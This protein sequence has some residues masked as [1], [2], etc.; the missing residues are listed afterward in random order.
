MAKSREKLKEDSNSS[1]RD[2]L[3]CE[4][5]EERVSR[6]LDVCSK[7]GSRAFLPEFV[8]KRRAITKNFSI[9]VVDAFNSD[10]KVLNF[11]K[12]FPGRRWSFNISKF[13]DWEKIKE[14]VDGELGPFIGWD[15]QTKLDEV[16]AREASVTRSSSHNVE[17]AEKIPKFLLEVISGIDFN[18]I[19]IEKQKHVLDGLKTLMEVAGQYDKGFQAIFNEVLKKLPSEGKVAIAQLEELMEKWSLKQ[20]TGVATLVQERLNEISRFKKAITSDETFE[21]K[22]ENSIHRILERSMW[23]VDER[24]WL[25]HSNETL[26][27]FIGEGLSKKDKKKYGDK[28][29]DFV[30]GSVDN[31]LII[32]ELKRPSHKLML[33]DLEQLETYLSVVEDYTERYPS[34]EA[35]L[36]GKRIDPELKRRLKFRRNFK[37]LTFSDLLENTEKR[38]SEYLKLDDKKRGL[39]K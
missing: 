26:R 28:R 3:I 16:I 2:Y 23:I 35:Y 34:Y 32:M 5:C 15:T 31:K 36:V 18:K 14:I 6:D 25:M 21:I 27:T 12:W 11:Y 38:Y 20:I 29:P 10:S 1:R 37:V 7:C 8:H 22:G 30:C 4:R 33:D 9:N 17:S 24:Y 13:T 19:D 39:D